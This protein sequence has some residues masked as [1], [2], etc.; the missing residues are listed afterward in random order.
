MKQSSVPIYANINHIYNKFNDNNIQ[1][2]IFNAEQKINKNPERID[3]D[4]L[5]ISETN[6]FLKTQDIKNSYNL[7]NKHQ[8]KVIIYL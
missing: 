5:G 2:N 8:L 3:K 4:S 6:T 1:L 7:N